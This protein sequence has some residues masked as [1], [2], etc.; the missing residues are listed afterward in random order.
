VVTVDA[1]GHRRSSTPTESFRQCDDVAAL[2][3]HLDA[4]R[5]LGL[6][7]TST[8]VDTTLEAFLNTTE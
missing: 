8:A 6:S 7:T 2:V 3:R 1:S 5:P 4:A